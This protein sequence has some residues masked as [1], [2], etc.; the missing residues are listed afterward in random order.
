VSTSEGEKAAAALQKTSCKAND[1]QH[2]L[3]LL[4]SVKADGVGEQIQRLESKLDAMKE[5]TTQLK[6]LNSVDHSQSST[7]KMNPQIYPSKTEVEIKAHLES[8]HKL[9]I[10]AC[11]QASATAA[12]TAQLQCM[13]S[14]ARWRTAA[15]CHT[16][17][18]HGPVLHLPAGSWSHNSQ[19][20]CC[21]SCQKLGNC[22]QQGQRH[23]E[24]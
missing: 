11:S 1:L 12:T 3:N 20:Q 23:R 6:D 10:G 5:R 2:T 14:S 21:Q 17:Q 18:E 19:L 22:W 9:K 8:V 16:I 24:A 13:D 7:A 15:H 4:L